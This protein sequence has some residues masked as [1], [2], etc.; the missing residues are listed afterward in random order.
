METDEFHEIQDLTKTM[1]ALL[2]LFIMS[3]V[4]TMAQG[5]LTRT[6]LTGIIGNHSCYSKMRPFGRF[7]FKKKTPPSVQSEVLAS[8]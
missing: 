5:E 4:D 6:K 1:L 8:G 7:I 2:F 3:A